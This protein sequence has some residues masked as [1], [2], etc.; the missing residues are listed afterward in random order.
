MST[1]AESSVNSVVSSDEFPAIPRAVG[2][3]IRGVSLCGLLLSAYLLFFSLSNSPTGPPGCGKAGVFDCSH[4]LNSRWAQWWGLPVTL[5]AIPFYMALLFASAFLGPRIPA[6]VR[7][8]AFAICLAAA[9]ALALLA[10]WFMSLQLL[11][12]QHICVFCSTAHLLHLSLA[13]V[14]LR[15]NRLTLRG[16]MYSTA[17]AGGL[18]L[19]LIA[20]QV[21]VDEPQQFL[22]A[23][24][25][26]RFD[27]QTFHLTNKTD[28]EFGRSAGARWLVRGLVGVDL[29]ELPVL[30]DP[31]APR[32]V[33]LMFDYACP[34]CRIMHRQLRAAQQ[35]SPGEFCVI[36]VSVPLHPRCNHYVRAD[37]PPLEDAC[38]L[39]QLSLA[40]WQ[41]RPDRLAEFDAWLTEAVLPPSAAQAREQAVALI[42]A[43]ALQQALGSAELAGRLERNTR[44][45]DFLERGQLPKLLLDNVYVMGRMRSVE[46]LQRVLA[47]QHDAK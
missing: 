43:E 38:P 4:V 2:W 1:T 28:L 21:L 41:Q 25:D 31:Q 15:G 18:L 40:V 33:A 8:R 14:M 46:E 39:A 29:Q 47:E 22:I 6:A 42:G 11:V 36:L 35:Q 19:L 12:L 20:G 17:A 37:V 34:I 44:L 7:R 32:V 3:W 30:G 13:A 9:L 26:H 16:T 10:V 45:Y 5:P 27:D 23:T 24:P